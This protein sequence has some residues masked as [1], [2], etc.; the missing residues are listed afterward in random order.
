MQQKGCI[1]QNQ[2]SAQILQIAGFDS[3]DVATEHGGEVR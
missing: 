1:T 3:D 2:S